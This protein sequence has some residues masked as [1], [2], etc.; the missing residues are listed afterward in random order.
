MEY[1]ERWYNYT[2]WKLQIKEYKHSRDIHHFQFVS[3][4][5]VD[6]DKAEAHMEEVAKCE[7]KM[8]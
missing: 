7:K 1:C 5:Q 3:Y 8:L 4:A 6:R 2:K